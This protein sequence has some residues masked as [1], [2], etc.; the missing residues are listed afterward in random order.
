MELLISGLLVWSLVHF[1]PSLAPALK[2][3]LIERL[4]GAGYKI[5]FTALMLCS[6]AMIIFGWRSSLP[7][8][9]YSLPGFARHAALLLMLVAFVLFGAAQYPTRIKQFVRHPQ[10]ASVAVWA[11]AHLMLNGDSRSLFLFGGLGL[12]AI[13]EMIFINRREGE[14]VKPAPPGWAR[15]LKGLVI[16]LVILVVVVMLHPYI[17]GVSIY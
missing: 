17:A 3:K 2:Q 14:W 15:E 4:G 8:H 13:L 1:I 9:L 6:L 10:L 12:W 11:L 16:S 7:S 5:A